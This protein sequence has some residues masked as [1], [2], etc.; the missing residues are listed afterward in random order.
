MRN[1][2]DVKIV[3]QNGVFDGQAFHKMFHVFKRESSQMFLITGLVNFSH[4][5]FHMIIIALNILL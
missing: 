1:I 3:L 4:K 2:S 5:N